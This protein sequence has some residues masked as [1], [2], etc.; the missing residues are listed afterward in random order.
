MKKIKLKESEYKVSAN[1]L[2]IYY[3]LRRKKIAGDVIVE[4]KNRS[5]LM[6][7]KNYRI[8]IA[9]NSDYE[10]YCCIGGRRVPLK[11]LHRKF[12][13]PTHREWWKAFRSYFC[14]PYEGYIIKLLIKK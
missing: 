13:Y 6:K 3:I 1:K 8:R 14:L 9:L 7:A 10:H 11:T 12:G 5:F 2:E 4:T